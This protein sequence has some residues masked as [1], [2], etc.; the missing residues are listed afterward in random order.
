MLGG[1]NP[2][3]TGTAIVGGLAGDEAAAA[4]AHD[5]IETQTALDKAELRDLERAEFYTEDRVAPEPRAEPHRRS[6]LD[7]LLRR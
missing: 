5:D 1:P 7:R 4:N 2:A 6:L 3:I